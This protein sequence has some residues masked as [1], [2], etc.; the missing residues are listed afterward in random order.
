MENDTNIKTNQKIGKN[1]RITVLS[2]ILLRLE[3]N[4]SGNFIDD[5]TELVKSRNFSMPKFV[6]QED[7]KYL[8]IE[9][10]YF[11]LEYI[12]EKP[13]VG[14]KFVPEQNLKV[15]LKGT[16]KYW[17]YNHIEARNFKT[18]G[19]SIDGVVNPTLSN[20]G[21][22]STDGFV[23]IDDSNSYIIRDDNYYKRNS[24]GI[25]IYLFMYKRNFG[26]VL[27]DYFILTGK[28]LMLPR[29]LFGII[30]NK[31]EEYTGENIKN[32]VKKFN[33]ND[34][35]INTIL[36]GS[37]WHSKNNNLYGLS[38]NNDLFIN[39]T[40]FINYLKDEGIYLGV[41][42]NPIIIS[43]KEANIE[44][45]KKQLNITDDK[46]IELN[47]YNKNMMDIY[48]K[49]FIEPLINS[50]INTL[51][52]D[53]NTKSTNIL[54]AISYYHSRFFI[55][56]GLKSSVFSRN[57]LINTHSSNIY[58]TGKTIVGW[59]SLNSIPEYI[60]GACNSGLSFVSTDIGG[61]YGGIEDDELY[62]R[63]VEFGTFSPIFRLSSEGS[64]FYK[65]E[66]WMWDMN[67]LN[68]VKYY[69]RF[70]VQLMPYL[71]TEAHN[72]SLSGIPIIRPL[73]YANPEI[74]DEPLYKNEYYFGSSL[75]VSP[76]TKPKDP[77]MNRSIQRL[78]L[79][80]G[81]WYDFKTGI[82]FTGNKRYISFYKDEDYPVFA[83]QGSIIPLQILNNDYLNSS[84]NPDG[85]E[86]HIFPGKSNTYTVYEDD[87]VSLSDDYVKTII[88][89]N[90][91]LNN[92]TVII[93]Q[94]I[95]NASLIP[96]IRTFI[97]RFRN[98]RLPN[99]ISVYLGEDRLEDYK[100]YLDENDFVVKINKVNS[101]KQLTIN[102]KGQDIEIENTRI[103][104]KDID[105]IINDLKIKTVLK[106]EVAKV[107]FS[108]L[109]IKDKRINIRKLKKKGL[110]PRYINMFLK[111]LEYLEENI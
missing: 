1:Y 58:Y 22:Y 26:L 84:K 90:Y 93:R 104:N 85:F 102:C 4:D 27:R 99:D 71:Y 101:Y 6:L 63:F 60:I 25:D 77:I 95:K 91:M 64:R 66:P 105:D 28:P 88:D 100:Y 37:K 18:V 34:I 17:Y 44:A 21:L 15:L 59:E 96:S 108:D 107:M 89:Y 11:R 98:T 40:D 35:P 75:F 79:P 41:T 65:R 69:M 70:R 23:S 61:Y 97:I 83:S 74:Y 81:I 103:I 72:Y 67:T 33:K 32:L 2:D 87:G 48:F 73:Y 43:S 8:V 53:Y 86:I 78:F 38:W 19:V 80:N 10:D 68:V 56:Q 110:H 9:T 82:K 109:E 5:T 30:W 16:D 42:I 45:F 31:D 14:T 106:D 7:E 111:L 92:Y 52:I 94:D 76:I 62:R 13:F 36:L 12:K 51:L 50:G 20:K 29:Y 3:Y 39:Y 54:R 49:T 47:P 57:G 55:K 46:D 24:S